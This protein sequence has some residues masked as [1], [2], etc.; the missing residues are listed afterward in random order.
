VGLLPTLFG[1][2][3]LGTGAEEQWRHH[4]VFSTQAQRTR[5]C[6]LA[7]GSRP[8]LLFFLPKSDLRQHFNYVSESKEISPFLPHF[9]PQQCSSVAK[10]ISHFATHNNLFFLFSVVSIANWHIKMPT[11]RQSLEVSMIK[12]CGRSPSRARLSGEQAY[13]DR[14]CASCLSLS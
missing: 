8:A 1:P 11:Q 12:P 3:H 6:S 5:Q 13:K 2:H 10:L 9:C 4:C 7:D 14:L